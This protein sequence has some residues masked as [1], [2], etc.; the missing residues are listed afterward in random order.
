[1]K[2]YM[3]NYILKNAYVRL[4]L[5]IQKEKYFYKNKEKKKIDGDPFHVQIE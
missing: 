5:Q 2:D 3:Q 1:M 4:D